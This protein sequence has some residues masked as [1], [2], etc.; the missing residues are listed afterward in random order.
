M[1]NIVFLPFQSFVVFVNCFILCTYGFVL[2]IKVPCLTLRPHLLSP[3]IPFTLL[4]FTP[5][6]CHSQNMN[7]VSFQSQGQQQKL[8]TAVFEVNEKA[9]PYQSY[10]KAARVQDG[11]GGRWWWDWPS[12]Q[13]R[14]RRP[15][16][17]IPSLLPRLKFCAWEVF[18]FLKSQLHSVGSVLFP[19]AHRFSDCPYA[20]AWG[21]GSAFGGWGGSIGWQLACLTEWQR[22]S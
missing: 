9:E 1:P 4:P 3:F 19:F 22:W 8:L 7:P 15:E 12:D 6:M 18:N 11:Q 2:S 20:G 13:V 10:W 16:D 17:R 21:G 14:A 5:A